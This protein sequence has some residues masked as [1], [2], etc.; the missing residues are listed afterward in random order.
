MNVII[1]GASAGIGKAFAETFARHGHTVLAVARRESR[2][3]A[4]SQEM[5]ANHDAVL[6]PLSLDL[7][8]PNAPQ[9]LFET[10]LRTFDAVHVLVNNAGMSPYQDFHEMDLEHIRQAI[11]LNIQSLTELCRRFIP[12]MLAHGQPCHLVNVGSLGGY[13]PL[14]HFAVYSGSKHYVRVFTDLLHHELRGTKIHVTA[15]HPGA[16]LTE[17]PERAGERIKPFTRKFMMT[18]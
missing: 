4:L 9:T 14:P 12:H 6:H 8:V 15:L 11:A 2:L 5:A 10:A 18:P 1:T 16:T 17:F 7:T 3:Q 13:A